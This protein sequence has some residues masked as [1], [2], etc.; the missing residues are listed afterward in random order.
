MIILKEITFSFIHV[1]IEESKKWYFQ[2]T[3]IYI[4]ITYGICQ[5]EMSL[6]FN[7]LNHSLIESYG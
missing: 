4:K 1:I 5:D 7:S 3:A 2:K 6:S